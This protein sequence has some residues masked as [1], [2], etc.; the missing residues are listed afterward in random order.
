MTSFLIAAKRAVK[1]ICALPNWFVDGLASHSNFDYLAK[2]LARAKSSDA[3][4][5]MFVREHAALVRYLIDLRNFQEHTEERR[6]IVDDFR[7]LPDGSVNVPMWHLEGETPRPIAAEMAVLV[8][9]LIE[10]AEGL[11][12]VLILDA[13]ANRVPYVLEEV[14]LDSRDPD[15]PIRFR[16]GIDAKRLPQ[17]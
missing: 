1:H 17:T 7:M 2:D 10:L 9:R 13:V 11:L 15:N 12:I 14:P 3:D 6:T 5:T 4:V 16:L 8:D